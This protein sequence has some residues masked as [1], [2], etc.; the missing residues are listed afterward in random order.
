MNKRWRIEAEITF[1]PKEEENE[2]QALDRVKEAL[3]R[4][5]DKEPEINHYH[6]LKRPHTCYEFD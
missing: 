2:H 3:N 4:M 1:D 6:I 5:L